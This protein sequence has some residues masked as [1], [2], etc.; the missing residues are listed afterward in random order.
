MRMTVME[1]NQLNQQQQLIENKIELIKLNSETN[2]INETPIRPK[3]IDESNSTVINSSRKNSNTGS[4]NNGCVV[5]SSTNSQ[6]PLSTLSLSS[7]SSAASSSAARTNKHNSTS[8][9][10]LN[11]T[12][13]R[14][15][16]NSIT[17]KI[18]NTEAMHLDDN[19]LE[20]FDEND[21]LNENDRDEAE[22]TSS[23]SVSNDFSSSHPT[24]KKLKERKK[25]VRSIAQQQHQLNCQ[26]SEDLLDENDPNNPESEITNQN[27]IH[28][29]IKS[30]FNQNMNSAF[31][32]LFEAAQTGNIAKSAVIEAKMAAAAAAVEKDDDIGNEHLQSR[33]RSSVGRSRAGSFRG[34][35][36]AI[37]STKENNNK[38][39]FM[40]NNFLGAPNQL[41]RSVSCK[42]PG[43]F[44]KMK[45]R[46][47]SPN[48]P[49][50]DNN[51]SINGTPN[52]NR[53]SP[54]IVQKS[55]PAGSCSNNNN[56]NGRR[57]T[58]CSITLMDNL[59][60]GIQQNRTGSLPFEKMNGDDEM[61]MDQDNGEV[62]RVRQFHTTNNGLVINRGDSFKRSFKRST[63]SI[64]SN[65]NQ[66]PTTKKENLLN[67]PD[68]HD[69]YMRRMSNVSNHDNIINETS[70]N[71]LKA[72]ENVNEKDVN[73]NNNDC[74]SQQDT[75]IP[76]INS[77]DSVATYLVYLL[78]ATSVGKNAL[79]KQ[80]Y[81]SEYRGTYEINQYTSTG[82]KNLVY[83]LFSVVIL[84]LSIINA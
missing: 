36:R 25:L 52:L 61:I 35:N 75:K 65:A 56:N 29:Q 6:I 28:S 1:S 74:A 57:G 72:C 33:R 32:E 70:F 23:N 79:I 16:G 44:K 55:S 22:D 38:T 26:E 58:Q 67:L 14:S 84:I 64:A 11:Q 49:Q 40:E 45:S 27:I 76:V 69:G 50:N 78:G 30:I 19:E 46:N 83:L 47:A 9:P 21:E 80:F 4:I 43:S 51:L 71:T 15:S 37:N 68:A 73:N 82:I 42:R 77:Q 62:Y 10:P 12:S 41:T 39:L 54:V 60:N 18:T 63:H 8:T 13:R 31:D 2:I 48:R 66:S 3:V 81:T 34:S 24:K 5:G 59:E 17:I 53:Q 7:N 20:K